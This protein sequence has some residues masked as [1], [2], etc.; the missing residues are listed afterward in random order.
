M[1]I[2]KPG[3]QAPHKTTQQYF[4]DMRARAVWKGLD[5]ILID[6][7]YDYD[8]GVQVNI[9][10]EI[11]Y[12]KYRNSFCIEVVKDGEFHDEDIILTLGE[13][14]DLIKTLQR[15]VRLNTLETSTVRKAMGE[16]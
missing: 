7:D 1:T 4:D 3:A 14:K 8:K 16:I 10:I 15:A 13:M 12:H 6:Y 9:E 11:A 2:N 5:T